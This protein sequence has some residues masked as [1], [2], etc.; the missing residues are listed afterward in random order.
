MRHMVKSSSNDHAPLRH[1]QP[2]PSTASTSLLERHR[3]ESEQREISAQLNKISELERA[4]MKLTATQTLAEVGWGQGSELRSVGVKGQSLFEVS[5]VMGPTLAGVIPGSMVRHSPR[6]F[7]GQ[8]SDTC[9]G[10][11]GVMVYF[12][13]LGALTFSAT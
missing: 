5:R 9:C 12:H 2:V 7:R 6:S 10:H 8:G 3:I 11:S 13:D 4:Q 1:K